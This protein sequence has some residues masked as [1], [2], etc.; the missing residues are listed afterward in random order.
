MS[1]AA[2]TSRGLIATAGLVLGPLAAAALFGGPSAG[3]ALDEARPELNA[4]AAVAVWM[5]IWWLTEAVAPAATG[6]LPL[7]LLPA[8][9]ILPA[10]AVAA[11][12]GDSLI[13]LY[14][15]GFLIALAA[16][17][18]GLQRRLALNVIA[19]IGDSPA[20][21]VL[22]VMLATGAMS[23]WMSNTATTL[24]MLPLAVSLAD[25]ARCQSADPQAGRNFGAAVLLA[26]AYAASIGGYGTLIGT[27][28]NLALK[29]IYTQE[30]PQGPE[31]SFGGWMLLAAP[32]AGVMLIVSW[33]LMT[34]LLLPL[35]GSNLLGEKE[36]IAAER[37]SLGPWTPAEVRIAAIFVIT[38]LLWIFRQPVAGFGWAP[39]LRN[40]A[41][42]PTLPVDDSTVAIAMALVCFVVPRSGWRGPALAD[43]HL[44][45]RVPW[46]VLLLFG[47]GLALAE[48]LSSSGLDAHLG[49][50]FGR[51]LAGASPLAMC[52]A[53]ATGMTFFSELASNL[54]CTTMSLPILASVAQNLDCDPRLLMVTATIAASSAFM[55]PAGTPPNAIVYGSGY[56][57]LRDM[58]VTGFVLNW[59]GILL[60]VAAIYLLGGPALGITWAGLPDW[61]RAR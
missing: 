3:W 50:W 46:G 27:P 26:I 58:L 12:Y 52:A 1:E 13:Y 47:G 36:Y 18:T 41:S 15:G 17:E 25:R 11:C 60:I 53:T 49:R 40:L 29:Q 2:A 37:R 31:L 57:R 34:R 39:A 44:A 32:L 8:L 51:Q 45:Q 10:K 20:R 24:V 23:M 33:L 48:G 22:G 55:L 6:L 61:A 59:A 28:P 42:R 35:G 54:A 38:A 21:V 4:M 43:W 5:A 19:V 56:V 14:L 7:A 9:S 16:E 30:F